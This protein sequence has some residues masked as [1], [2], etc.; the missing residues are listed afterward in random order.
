M[1]LINE[2]ETQ[3]QQF[4]TQTKL[5]HIDLPQLQSGYLSLKVQTGLPPPLAVTAQS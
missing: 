2:R 3:T 4:W 1:D 5:R